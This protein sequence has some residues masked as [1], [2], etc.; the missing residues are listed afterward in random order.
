MRR[1]LLEIAYDGTNYAGWQIQKNGITIE[2]VLNETLSDFLGEDIHVIGASRTDAG[3]HALSA[4]AAFD[5]EATMPDH[6][7]AYA[8]NR[9]LPEDIV[10]QASREVPS[11]FHPRYARSE[12]TYEYRILNRQMRIPTMRYDTFFYYRPLEYTN[13][14][15]KAYAVIWVYLALMILIRM[16]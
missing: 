8:L 2:Q 10:I 14:D 7:F 12:K 3:V 15:R 4:M 16:I 13:G 5:T 6:K 9:Y 1:I 11:D